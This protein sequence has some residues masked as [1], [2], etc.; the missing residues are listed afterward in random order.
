M[1]GNFLD[2]AGQGL[3]IGQ[4]VEVKTAAILDFARQDDA[5]LVDGDAFLI[6][7]VREDDGELPVFGEKEWP[8]RDILVFIGLL[9]FL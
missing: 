2:G 4:Y 9:D 3:A 8:M 5:F 1:R 7:E 6:S